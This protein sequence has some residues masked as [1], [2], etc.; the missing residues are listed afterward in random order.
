MRVVVF[1]VNSHHRRR[2][3]SSHDSVVM[4]Y[5]QLQRVG[6]QIMKQPWEPL[7]LY[8]SFNRTLCSK[9]C[10]NII[11]FTHTHTRTY[12][13]MIIIIFFL[14]YYY[15]YYLE[16]SGSM[17]THIYALQT[18]LTSGQNHTKAQ[19]AHPFH[20]IWH[21]AVT[22]EVSKDMLELF[23]TNKSHERHCSTHGA[24]PCRNKHE[25]MP[26]THSGMQ[27]RGCACCLCPLA[28]TSALSSV[29]AEFY[30]CLHRCAALSWRMCF[31]TT[32]NATFDFRPPFHLISLHNYSF[33]KSSSVLSIRYI[34][35]YQLFLFRPLTCFG[36]FDQSFKLKVFL[37]IL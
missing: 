6:K 14:Y 33:S 28:F 23:L 16:I 9:T 25:C 1:I 30:S 7:W 26:C 17:S 10:L 37:C 11:S 34:K 4:F 32:N 13:I 24:T 15:Y 29:S 8:L 20:I 12:I 36:V 19:Y 31:G 27:T 18:S 3:S 22:H 5:S 35:L 2:K 21:A